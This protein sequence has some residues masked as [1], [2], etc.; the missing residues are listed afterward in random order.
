M[1]CVSNAMS[2][3]YRVRGAGAGPVRHVVAGAAPICFGILAVVETP[4]VHLVLLVKFAGV[5]LFVAGSGASLLART[6]EDRRR[7]THT[8]ASSG[9]FLAWSGGLALASMSGI[10]LTELWIVLGLGLSL[11]AHVLVVTAAERG[12]S[13]GHR[14]AFAALLL[15]I[16]AA[17]IFRPVFGA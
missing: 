11:A 2:T 10:P 12:A 3:M 17:M 15:A 1:N 9:L 5:L 6:R 4:V 16:L 13:R 8:I 14:L 7:A